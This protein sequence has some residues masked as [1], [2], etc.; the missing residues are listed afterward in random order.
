MQ[1]VLVWTFYFKRCLDSFDRTSVFKEN[2]LSTSKLLPALNEMTLQRLSQH[3]L[4]FLDHELRL[5][6]HVV[7]WVFHELGQEGSRLGQERVVDVAELLAEKIEHV[8]RCQSHLNQNIDE[9]RIVLRAWRMNENYLRGLALGLEQYLV[10]E[11]AA[12]AFVMGRQHAQV[13]D[14]RRQVFV[15]ER[16]VVVELD[17]IVDLERKEISVSVTREQKEAS[18]QGSLDRREVASAS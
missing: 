5:L 4:E 9:S 18:S 3:V 10:V 1:S 6:L 12:Q 15:D 11:L 16:L 14:A 7:H 2:L 13:G 17:L 8:Q